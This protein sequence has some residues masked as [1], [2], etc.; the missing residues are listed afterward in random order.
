MSIAKFSMV[1]KA[2]A[3]NETQEAEAEREK[4]IAA[5]I[6]GAPD[7]KK[8]AKQ[9]KKS[10]ERRSNVGKK[11]KLKGNK[12]VITHT[13]LPEDLVRLDALAKAHG[14]TR[15]GFLNSLIR[16]AVLADEMREDPY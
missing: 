6:D 12:V 4:K 2:I 1:K 5:F 11:W 8:I 14:M 9:P 15:A 3:N 16:K 13:L 10:N 7:G